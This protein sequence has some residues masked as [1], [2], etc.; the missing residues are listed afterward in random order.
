MRGGGKF[1]EGK[2][3]IRNKMHMAPGKMSLKL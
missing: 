1:S 2:Y 3:G